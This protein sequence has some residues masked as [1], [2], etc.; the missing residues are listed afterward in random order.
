MGGGQGGLR[1]GDWAQKGVGSG[2]ILSD[3]CITCDICRDLTAGHVAPHDEVLS[4]NRLKT[5]EMAGEY[6]LTSRLKSIR[7]C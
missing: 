5:G 2:E 6:R 3:T 1:W 4:F 7:G